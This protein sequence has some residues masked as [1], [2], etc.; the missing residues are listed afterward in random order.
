MVKGGVDDDDDDVGRAG[1]ARESGHTDGTILN[2]FPANL[3]AWPA[4]SA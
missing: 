3:S 1:K 2:G 4:L